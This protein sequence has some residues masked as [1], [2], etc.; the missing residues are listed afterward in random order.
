M[1]YDFINPSAAGADDFRGGRPLRAPFH[2]MQRRKR[3]E[4]AES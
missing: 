2:P 4:V 3:M 1:P